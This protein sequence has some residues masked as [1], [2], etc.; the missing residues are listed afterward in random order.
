MMIF[1]KAIHRRAFLQGL[2]TTLALPLM[3]SM[4]PAFAA[5]S[6]AAAQPARR[7]S[8]LYVPNGIIMEKWTPAKEGA[9]FELTPIM[10]PLAPFRDRMLVL[11]GLAQKMADP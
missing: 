5:A 2:G 6:D 4:I 1:K 10:E 11:T 8:V 3:D 7:L 9:G